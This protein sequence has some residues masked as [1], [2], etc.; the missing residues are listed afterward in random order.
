MSSL[1]KFV[2]QFSV[3][4]DELCLYTAPSGIIPTLTFLKN[5]T[6]SQFKSAMD[7]TAVDFPTKSQRFEV[8]YNLLSVRH[9]ARIRVKT[10]A[11]EITPVPSSTGLYKGADWFERE[12]WDMYG[13][14]F[15]NHPD[16]RRIL[17]D[18]GMIFLK[19]TLI[20]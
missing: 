7:I 9:N 12:V 14:F 15:V 16:L 20:D 4:K 17:T 1:P 5:H 19:I 6:Q 3:Y 18:Y 10:Y 2:Q 13:V 8:V 11:D